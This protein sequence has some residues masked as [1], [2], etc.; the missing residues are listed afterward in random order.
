MSDP[1]GGHCLN[2]IGPVTEV[3]GLLLNPSLPV[4][5]VEKSAGQMKAQFDS[6][7][8]SYHIPTPGQERIRLT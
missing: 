2:S 7:S 4:Y 1:G 5:L 6:E 3:L 8:T